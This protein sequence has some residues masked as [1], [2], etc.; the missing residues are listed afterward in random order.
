MGYVSEDKYI[1]LK[2]RKFGKASGSGDE[3]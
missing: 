1:A 2:L 3:A